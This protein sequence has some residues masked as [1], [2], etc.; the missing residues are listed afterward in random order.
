M[1]R[2]IRLPVLVACLAG[3]V[4]VG[5]F[6]GP[7]D[8]QGQL[9]PA[10]TAVPRELT[11]YRDVVKQVLPAVVSIESKVKAKKGNG[12]IRRGRGQQPFE[13]PPGAPEQFR[14]FFE[15]P[16][17]QPEDQ[18]M[19]REQA[20]GFGSGFIVD[21]AGVIVTNN[22]V[23]D[24]A[25]E[26]EVTLTDGRKFKSTD[27]KTDE[28][29]DL[30]IV[31]VKATDKLPALKFGDSSLMEIGDRVLAVGAP[32][33]LS[34]TV[35]NGIISAKGRDLGR[36]YDDFL[37][38]DA[39]I[40]HGN[41]GGPLVNLAG[42]VV[43]IN[44]AIKSESGGFQGIGF[45]VSS[46]TARNVMTQLQNSG[47][48]KRGYLGIEMVGE[49]SPEVA[50]RLGMK[51]HE[52]VVVARVVPNSPAAKAGLK[53]DDVITA[54]NGQAVR[55][56][57]TLLRS[58]GNMAIGKST[59]VTVLRDGKPQNL[60][61]TLEE[62]PKGYGKAPTPTGGSRI[63]RQTVA[64]EKFGL[65]LVDLPADRT[66]AFGVT[67]GALVVRVDADGA[68]AE[69]GIGQGLVITKVDRKDVTSADAAKKAIE[70]GD[71]T[72]GVLLHLRSD[73]GITS[74]VLLKAEKK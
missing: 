59:D 50:A 1:K 73:R 69:A 20:I 17:R 12:V 47:V 74:I 23:V 57:R 65:E 29:T 38:T 24:G 21:P 42:E 11:S 56:N 70:Q 9:T 22:H 14:K 61:L 62:Q 48:V 7:P 6:V 41:S 5:R 28:D 58:V 71:A 19:P 2:S 52:G 18:P 54:V 67:G 60:S 3:G 36:R 40:N 30:A 49:V 8:A 55:D 37:Q 27:I 64:V 45:A 33:R 43:G 34:G 13:M 63:E 72:K 25:D 44:A 16:Q 51:E 66:D 68:A 15:E 31:R 53:A 32:F 39:A 35:T 4:A 26:V 46:N 10:A